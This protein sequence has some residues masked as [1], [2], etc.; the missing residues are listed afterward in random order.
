MGL[1]RYFTHYG[2]DTTL[3]DEEALMFGPKACFLMAHN[4]WVMGDDPLKNFARKDSYVYL[5]R[6][7]VAWGDSVK[8][9]YGDEPKDSPYLW[10]LMKRYCEYTAR[11]F[12]GIRLD[13]CHSTP[14]HVA[15]VS[16]VQGCPSSLTLSK[17]CSVVRMIQVYV[18][19]NSC[20]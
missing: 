3:E 19:A 16:V 10:D 7:L 4:G 17:V 13:N 5:R 11:I 1:C 6:E 8:L 2:K 14:I 15:E 9:R 18:L 12:H 20:Q